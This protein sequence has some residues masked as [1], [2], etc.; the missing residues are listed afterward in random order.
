MRSS[1]HSKLYSGWFYIC[2]TITDAHIEKITAIV[3]DGDDCDESTI[4]SRAALAINNAVADLHTICGDILTN[5]ITTL[6]YDTYEPLSKTVTDILYTML[7]DWINWGRIVAFALE[8]QKKCKETHDNS[9]IKETLINALKTDR[10][11]TWIR[12]NSGFEGLCRFV[13]DGR[14]HREKKIETYSNCFY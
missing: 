7:E 3:L 2:R 14:A 9:L 4:E 8:I 13:T 11:Q 6:N 5:L 1:F 10:V 12:N